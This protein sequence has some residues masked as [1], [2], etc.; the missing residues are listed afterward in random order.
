MLSCCARAQPGH[1]ST[2]RC[3]INIQPAF[4]AW[5]RAGRVN[6][7]N[8]QHQ[9]NVTAGPSLV[10]KPKQA[11]AQHTLFMRANMRPPG[12][13]ACCEIRAVRQISNSPGEVGPLAERLLCQLLLFNKPVHKG[14]AIGAL[15][16]APISLHQEI[17]HKPWLG[18]RPGR[19]GP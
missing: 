9:S 12:G 19:Q 16:S 1:R 18:F 10:T 14:I 15:H 17:M 11:E 3:Q 13:Q 7:S 4:R 2:V 5:K 8:M 6:T